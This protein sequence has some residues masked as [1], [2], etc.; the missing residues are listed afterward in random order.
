MD[1]LSLDGFLPLPAMRL[2]L[3]QIQVHRD[4]RSYRHHPFQRKTVIAVN[5]TA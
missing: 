4:T 5:L 1:A 3:P 2:A